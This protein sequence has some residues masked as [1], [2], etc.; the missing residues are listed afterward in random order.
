MICRRYGSKNLRER[1]CWSYIYKIT[2]ICTGLML[3]FNLA[4]FAQGSRAA[5]FLFEIG[6]EYYDRGDYQQALHELEKVL[7]VEPGHAKAL[8]Y[9]QIIEKKTGLAKEEIPI[10]EEIN[11][12]EAVAR[13]LEE[14]EA[15][16][17]AEEEVVEKAEEVIVKKEVV[18]VEE[19]VSFSPLERFDNFIEDVNENIAPVK[20]SGEFTLSLGSLEGE[21]VWKEA[22]GDYNETNWRRIHRD[23]GIN[24]YDPRVYN[25]LRVNIDTEN[26]EGFNFHSNITIDPWSFIGKTDSI[27]LS[28]AL[29]ERANVQLKYC[30]ADSSI[31]NE[32]YLTLD[33]GAAI[34]IPET[35]VVDGKVASIVVTNTWGESLTI[36]ELEIHREFW[37]IRELWIDYNRADKFYFRFFPVAYQD[38]A[39]TSDDPLQL[40]NHMIYWEESPW[41]DRWQPGILNTGASPVD[42]TRGEWEDDL[43]FFTRDSNMTRL[44]SL[45][46][47][48]VKGRPWENLTF[49]S[50]VASPKGLWQDY[51]AFD[52]I[53]GASRVKFTPNDRLQLGL[54]HTFRYGLD[55]GK[56]DA[57]NRVIG[58]DIFYNFASDFHIKAEVAYSQDE[59]DLTQEPYNTKNTG[60]AY[61][62][63]LQK[64]KVQEE[65]PEKRD[66]DE[67]E[68]FD[69]SIRLIYTR[70]DKGFYPAL[71][72]YRLTRKDPFWGRHI[73][74]KEPIELYYGGLYYPSLTWDDIRPYRIGD[75]VDIDR[76][77]VSLRLEKSFFNGDLHTLLDSRNAHQSSSGKYIETVSRAE[78]NW[79]VNDKLL[80]KF[81][82]IY[83]DLPD[84]TGGIDPFIYDVDTNEFFLNSEIEDG[85]DPSLKT[86]SCG[87]KYD[88]FD[89][90]SFDFIYE[91]TNDFTV[92]LD[93]YP[94]S[95]LNAGS[96]A[97][98][99]EEG[100]VWRK[101]ITS[102]YNQYLFPKPPY[103]WFNIYKAAWE[104]KPSKDLK[105]RLE[106]TKNDYKFAS[107]IDDN[108]NHWGLEAD[109]DIAE[110][111]ALK[112]SYIYA[113]SYDIWKHNNEGGDLEYSGHHNVFINLD[114]KMEDKGVFTLQFGEAAVLPYTTMFTTSPY[115]G[116]LPTLDTVHIVRAYFSRRF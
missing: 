32:T 33:K 46:G 25:R 57:E 106:F 17:F 52:N 29:G 84:T 88:F 101:S 107:Q 95:L 53:E 96:F 27:N 56:R 109:W 40:S 62:F 78:A 60:N 72:N 85:K 42:F 19:E 13:A 6:K 108:I 116:F 1:F 10:S 111:L 77:V 64:G 81:L 58:A 104:I 3:L 20:I 23:F 22:N 37:P 21:V 28:S 50:T 102:L 38:Q 66:E 12:A 115:G 31:I 112:F 98:Y 59:R 11:R 8:M 75:S 70:M 47:F 69:Y 65:R 105:F 94:R 113:K 7:L 45:R 89:R 26:E 36:P 97:T 30:S 80:I 73:H 91:Y 34:T 14:A 100:L 93:D 63:E 49:E 16:V 44:T 55:D 68:P 87:F 103:P 48:S 15:E 43:S 41:L 92:A 76:E 5:D 51:D 71:T 114:Y 61:R 86:V 2:I 4:A 110:N 35:K 74:F 90:L 99:T 67:E 39:L 79:Q 54:I 9:I 24:T 18:E 83:H 82:G